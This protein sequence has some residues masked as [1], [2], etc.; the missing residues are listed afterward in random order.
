MN[1]A[2]LQPDARPASTV[3][4]VLYPG[5]PCPAC[6]GEP[7]TVSQAGFL[8]TRPSRLVL[9]GYESC[10]LC[11]AVVQVAVTRLVGLRDELRARG[12]PNRQLCVGWDI[13][14]TLLEYPVEYPLDQPFDAEAAAPTARPNLPAFGHL[15]A[16]QDAGVRI[17]YITGRRHVMEQITRLQLA[18]RLGVP[19]G[20]LDVRMNPAAK[21][22]IMTAL[23]H[24]V[25]AIRAAG[26]D[27]Y[28]GDQELDQTAAVAC[29][30]PFVH[31]GV[32]QSG[33]DVLEAAGLPWPSQSPTATTTKPGPGEELQ[34]PAAP[35][36]PA[37]TFTPADGSE[38]EGESAGIPLTDVV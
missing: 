20:T 30:I 10:A 19:P 9:P 24:K 34:Q 8:A 17:V 31:A 3:Q 12:E 27:V 32:A 36:T 22:E 13:D 5:T 33:Q 23:L 26:C 16:L 28:V 38:E 6:H 1:P 21:F 37:Q 25:D 18:S 35:M 11:G 2:T 7:G 29:G 15:K 14:G 4:A